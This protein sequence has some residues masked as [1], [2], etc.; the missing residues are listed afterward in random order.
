MYELLNCL[1]ER[2][3]LRD[4]LLSMNNGEG[5]DVWHT[6]Q[7]FI[8]RKIVVIHK[9]VFEDEPEVA[10]ESAEELGIFR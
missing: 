2:G 1:L 6:C 5:S 7:H 4:I 8:Y 3:V 9:V 10:D